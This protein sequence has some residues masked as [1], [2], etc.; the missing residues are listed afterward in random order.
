MSF[1]ISFLGYRL[2]LNVNIGNSQPTSIVIYY[3]IL[4][5]GASEHE[6]YRF[7]F[8]YFYIITI[9]RFDNA[10][11]YIFYVDIILNILSYFF[12]FL[13]FYFDFIR[14]VS[15]AFPLSCRVSLFKFRNFP[16][17]RTIPAVLCFSHYKFS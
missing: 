9:K 6:V 15:L 11:S 14:M 3:D 8:E 2:K 1:C 13:F 5:F 12:F 17:I 7:Y 10:I 16:K 4:F